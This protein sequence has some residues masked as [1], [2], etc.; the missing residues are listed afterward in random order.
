MDD[1][2]RRIVE[3]LQADA[4]TTNVALARELGVSEKTIRSRV[5]QLVATGLIRFEVVVAHGERPSRMLFGVHALPGRRFDVAAAL[6]ER[7][8]VDHVH[9]ANGAFDVVVEAAFG[10]DAEA[11]EFFVREVEGLDGVKEAVTCHLVTE[12]RQIDK[13]SPDGPVVDT[14]LVGGFVV[15]SHAIGTVDELLDEACVLATEG[16][17]ADRALASAVGGGTRVRGLSAEYV[18]SH[19]AVIESGQQILEADARTDPAVKAEG[20][21]T[22]LA[23]PM[24]HGERVVGV[25]ELCF[26]AKTRLEDSYLATAQTVADHLGMVCVRLGEKGS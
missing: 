14:E 7:P 25:L 17:S 13:P 9:L 11:L 26:D 10:D 19:A 8:Q 5:S 3:L 20:F 1:L 23:L 12:F 24:R 4:R 15:S 2:D 22:S 18:G 6:V 16:L 21:V